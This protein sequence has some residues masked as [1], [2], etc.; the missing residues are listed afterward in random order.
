MYYTYSFV[1]QEVPVY[2]DLPCEVKMEGG[3]DQRIE[4]LDES[5]PESSSEFLPTLPV[6]KS[7]PC[8]V[9]HR[10][11]SSKSYLRDHQAVHSGE[12]R[13]SCSVSLTKG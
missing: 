10:A 2:P 13:F 6:N 3:D 8:L 5:E 1:L 11:F 9:C 7:F 12:R 4:L